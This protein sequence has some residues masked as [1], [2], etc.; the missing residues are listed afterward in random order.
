MVG[1]VVSV[2][3]LVITGICKGP[4][5]L[6]LAAGPYI[7]VREMSADKQHGMSIRSSAVLSKYKPVPGHTFSR[8]A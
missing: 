8:G 7:N 6:S 3:A 4:G 5:K 2:H 1:S